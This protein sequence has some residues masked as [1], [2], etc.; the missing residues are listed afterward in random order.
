VSLSSKA[1]EIYTSL[2]QNLVD[3]VYA[4]YMKSGFIWEQYRAKD[5]SGKGSHPFTGWTALITLI[6]AES[7]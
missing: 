5:G 7:Y 1:N 3:N 4:Q 2:R 6:M